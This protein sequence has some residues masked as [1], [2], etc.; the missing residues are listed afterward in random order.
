M[1]ATDLLVSRHGPGIPAAVAVRREATGEW[2]SDKGAGHAM[3][4]RGG[5]GVLRVLV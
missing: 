5:G 4:T 3:V 2:V 1:T